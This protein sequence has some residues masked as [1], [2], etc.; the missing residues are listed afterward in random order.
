MGKQTQHEIL[1]G[2]HNSKGRERCARHNIDMYAQIN[3]YD[4]KI[5]KHY[6]TTTNRVI[7]WIR[8]DTH[9]ANE[10]GRLAP[11]I[12]NRNFQIHTW[13]PK[14]SRSR[15]A[16][17]D[18]IFMSYKERRNKNIKYI[19]KAEKCDLEVLC[20]YLDK[21]QQIPYRRIYI[22][23]LGAIPHH[24]TET[25]PKEETPSEHDFTTVMSK[26]N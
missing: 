4:I 21:D 6:I 22:G 14:F 16:Q 26:N 24:K 1:D 7:M 17:L 8:T 2:F 10:I 19:I 15:K 18:K 3:M 25:K 20:K 5:F 13:I 12:R 23:V 9:I 11:R